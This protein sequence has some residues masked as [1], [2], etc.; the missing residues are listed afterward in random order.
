MGTKRFDVNLS[1]AELYAIR[2]SLR[3]T[4]K[5]PA[6]LARIERKIARLHDF[7]DGRTHHLALWT[8]DW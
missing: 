3:E 4:G 2:N 8:T 7:F 1:L 6:L 5:E